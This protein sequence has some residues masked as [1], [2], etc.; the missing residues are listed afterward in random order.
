MTKRADDTGS[1][2]RRLSLRSWWTVGALAVGVVACLLIG[3]L[4]PADSA[5]REWIGSAAIALTLLAVALGGRLA[6]QRRQGAEDG[7][8]SAA[9]ALRPPPPA[10]RKAERRGGGEW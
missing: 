4:L 3:P 5:A 9:G 6:N 8:R 10:E 7:R 1:S 2:P